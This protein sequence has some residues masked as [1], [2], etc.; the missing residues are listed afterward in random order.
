MLVSNMPPEQAI[1]LQL[2]WTIYY[3]S[4]DQ[5]ESILK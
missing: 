5:T 2:K 1:N 4:L 3:I